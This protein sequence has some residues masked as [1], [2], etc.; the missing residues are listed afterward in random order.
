MINNRDLLNSIR[1]SQSL[2][3]QQ[4]IPVATSLTGEEL[5]MAILEDYPTAKNA[6][7]NTLTNRI[8]K[9]MF[10]NK[11]Y[12][13]P[14]KVFHRGLLPYGKNIQQL[15]VEMAEKK[16]FNEHFAGSDS[17]E[18]DLIKA[19]APIVDVL[20]VEQNIQYKFKTSISHEQLRGAFNSEYGLNELLNGIVDSLYSSVNY[21][22][23]MD[24][25]RILTHDGVAANGNNMEEGL[26]QQIGNNADMIVQCGNTVNDVA[27]AI[28]TWCNKLQFPSN[29]YNLAGVVN[30]TRPEDMVVFVTPELKAQLDVNVL[31]MAFNLPY[32]EAV[33]RMIVVD[34]L[35]KTEA[36][37]QVKCIVADKDI[38]QCYDTVNRT[39]TFENIDLMV[40]N[41]FAHKQG[42]MAGCKYANAIVLI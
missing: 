32:A 5:A 35:G 36:G 21:H 20:F 29:K 2:E 34:D 25:K 30:W 9:D 26:V 23:F 4:L 22:E 8:G 10:F 28:K 24:M 40:I 31:A 12:E 19:V 37:N 41:Y 42:I 6:F 7:I 11:V 16:G 33:G 14:Y 39:G 15:F 1:A 3:Y 38:I 17:N 18:G 13:N 27:V